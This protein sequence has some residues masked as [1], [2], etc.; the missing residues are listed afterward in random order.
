MGREVGQERW[1]DY[2]RNQAFQNV[3]RNPKT[4]GRKSRNMPNNSRCSPFWVMQL[5]PSG[6]IFKN[7]SNQHGDDTSQEG[8]R[9]QCGPGDPCP[10]RYGHVSFW[11]LAKSESR[12]G[13][14]TGGALSWDSGFSG[15]PGYSSSTTWFLLLSPLG[16]GRLR[17]S[18]A[19]YER[20][21]F[22][23]LASRLFAMSV[24]CWC[25]GELRRRTRGT[26]FQ[27]FMNLILLGC[28]FWDKPNWK[29]SWLQSGE[30]S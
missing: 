4:L 28:G 8:W 27:R 21:S 6:F 26:T 24:P 23:P 1:F 22:T 3:R 9:L 25:W 10:A 7:L 29:K 12:G 20:C 17:D 19:I 18:V 14:G 16:K 2:A 30:H 11:I 15:Q 5:G 13:A